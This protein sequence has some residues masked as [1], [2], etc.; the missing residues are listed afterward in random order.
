MIVIEQSFVK[1]IESQA[2]ISREALGIEVGRT[3]G[4]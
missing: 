3:E 2:E 1:A 4:S